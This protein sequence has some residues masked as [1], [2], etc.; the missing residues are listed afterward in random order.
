[1]KRIYLSGPMTGIPLDNYPA[2]I[3]AAAE[4]RK[5]GHVVT[6]PAEIKLHDEAGWE[7]YMK[8]DIKAMCDCETIALLPGWENSK[9]AN[10][11]LHIAHRV[12]MEV[13][14]L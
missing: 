11:E 2:F 3:A 12:G 14:F 6:N 5:Q 9:G 13:M 4:L 7:D 8:A 1:M 10:L